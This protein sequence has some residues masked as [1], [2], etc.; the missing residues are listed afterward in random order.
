MAD[1]YCDTC[2]RRARYC[3]RKVSGA[4]GH[5]SACHE[6]ACGYH[7]DRYISGIYAHTVDREPIEKCEGH[8]END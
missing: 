3:I 6:P 1:E 5:M 4:Y 7:R 2:G 8:L